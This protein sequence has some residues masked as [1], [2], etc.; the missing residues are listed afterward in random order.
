VII[1][2]VQC[3]KENDPIIPEIDISKIEKSILSNPKNELLHELS[4]VLASTTTQKDVRQFL[5]KETCKR[6]DGDFDMLFVKSLNEKVSI[7]DGSKGYMTFNEILQKEF[8]K[9]SSQLKSTTYGDFIENI[10]DE[11]PLLQIS[12]PEVYDSSTIG[13]DEINEKLDVSFIQ[14]EFN[15]NTEYLISY[16]SLGTPKLLNSQEPPEKPV[17]IIGQNESLV[18]VPKESNSRK[19][20]P[21]YETDKYYYYLPEDYEQ[22]IEIDIIEENQID[23]I[24]MQQGSR[25]LND[26]RDYL[27][28]A[29]FVSKTT[30]RQVEPWP[31]GRPEFKVIITY[32]EL[33]NGQH[34]VKTLTKVLPKDGWVSRYLIYNEIKTKNLDIPIIKWS[35]ATMGDNMKYTWIEIDN[36]DKQKSFNTTYSTKFEDGSTISSSITLTLNAEDDEAG[37]DIVY[38][39]DSTTGEGT[40]YNTGVVRFW[41]NQQ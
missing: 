5:K 24:Q 15:E 27:N 38:Y 16:D 2:L 35:K 37:E 22:P 1:L 41:I 28:K 39:I 7:S 9:K 29:K 3:R 17:I 21:Y 36:S 31:S 10:I 18:V 20:I 26:A 12:I 30:W 8:Q 40:E 13:W 6:F 11:F 25:D 14:N 4:I 19:A 32:A 23:P 33:L 34:V